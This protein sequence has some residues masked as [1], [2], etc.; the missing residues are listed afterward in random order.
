M[1]IIRVLTAS[2]ATTT[3]L[4]G[5][6]MAHASVPAQKK[7]PTPSF[8]ETIKQGRE[9]VRA[10]LK[11]TNSTSASVAL[12]AD[13]K[14]VWR[15]TFGRVNTA[16]KKPS[17]KTMYGVGSVS[18]TVTAIS[19]MQLVDAGKV[20]LD[21]PV[22]RYI[23]DFRM[24]SPQYRQ[25]TV[26]MLL[27]HSAGLPGTDYA[28]SISTRP[29]PGYVSRVLAGLR[30]SHLKT[31]PGAMNVYCNDCYTLAG[32]VVERVSG[33]PYQDYVAANIFKPLGMKHSMYGSP[34]PGTAAPVIQ[35]GEAQ[36]FLVTNLD[37]TGGLISTPTDMARVAM[38]FT[39]GGVVGGKRIISESAVS[40]MAVDQT[41]T[42]L[43][44]APP[45]N[46]RYGLG[47]D[48]MEDPALKAAGVRGWTKGGDLPQYHTGFTI[49][50][51]QGLAVIV[52]GAGTTFSSTSAETIGQTVLLNALVETGA[53]K[54]FP[55]QISGQP[56][57]A[58]AT[59]KQVKRMTGIFM[60]QNLTAK[61][62][63][64]K[65]RSLRL[66]ILSDGKWVPQ[67]GRLVRRADGSFWSTS[68][69]GRSVKLVRSWVARTSRCVVSAARE[70][71]APTRL[72]VSVC[73]RGELQR[74][75]GSSGWERSGFWPTKIRVRPTG[76]WAPLLWR[77]R[78]SLG[79][80]ATCWPRER[81]S[82]PFRSMPPPA[83]L[84]ARCSL[85]SRSCRAGTCTTSTSRRSRTARSG[86]PSAAASCSRTLRFPTCPLGRIQSPSGRRVT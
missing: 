66:M 14:V 42:T 22:V 61:V 38:I 10:Q 85:R 16:G 53:I 49:A 9:A 82:S 36:P 39:G 48:S 40:Q 25:I 50:P 59:A 67:P 17:F 35:D 75:P 11:Q 44:T 54:R 12:V 71:S 28:D 74:R 34:A 23:P 27:N 29:L 32:L 26:R 77:S 69:M 1:L 57:A 7:K 19:I 64:A 15:Q 60:A 46:F 79:C 2:I 3:I 56:P 4:G 78:R 72:W 86:C 6:P 62:V 5:V 65:G 68:S 33:M 21:A 80:R 73:A 18:K 81:W 84:E 47:W 58:K 8:T 83:T 51:D 41:T 43:T 76:R 55:K 30:T 24:A 13:G 70:P 31:T 63:E 37:A 45:N 20:S 52:E